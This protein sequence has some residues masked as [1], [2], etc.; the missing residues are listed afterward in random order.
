MEALQVFQGK[1]EKF[2]TYILRDFEVVGVYTLGF[3]EKQGRLL[4]VH[5]GAGSVFPG[6]LSNLW[7]RS[8]PAKIQCDEPNEHDSFT[9]ANTA[10][11]HQ[12]L[13]NFLSPLSMAHL[14]H[15]VST[16]C[17]ERSSSKS[18]TYRSPR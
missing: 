18:S 9:K 12:S 1:G 8:T 15:F 5:C 17:R 13:F 14:Q 16:T 11:Q 10:C 2:V 3:A 6:T 4:T 7:S